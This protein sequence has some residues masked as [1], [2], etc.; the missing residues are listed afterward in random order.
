M[1]KTCNNSTREAAVC[2][3]VS[4][5]QSEQEWLSKQQQQHPIK[6]SSLQPVESSSSQLES[7]FLGTHFLPAL[8]FLNHDAC[9]PWLLLQE[10]KPPGLKAGELDSVYHATSS[11]LWSL[12]QV[13]Q[14]SVTPL[15]DKQV[16]SLEEP[17]LLAQTSCGLTVLVHN[18]ISLVEMAPSVTLG[19]L[20]WASNCKKQRHNK[21]FVHM[22]YR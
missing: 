10:R 4:L 1:G 19:R 18:H 14:S 8:I 17:L 15:G 20:P 22:I 16:G 12:G 2:I 7:S 21:Q 13:I 3:I 11:S 6:I 5:S 9:S